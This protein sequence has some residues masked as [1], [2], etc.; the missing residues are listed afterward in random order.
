MSKCALFSIPEDVLCS[1]AI[2]DCRV[3][4]MARTCRSMHKVLS[5]RCSPVQVT[6]RKNVLMR[7]RL[8][9]EFSAGMY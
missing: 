1:L 3:L 4:L 5:V 7:S 2:P 9:K 8:A 6:V